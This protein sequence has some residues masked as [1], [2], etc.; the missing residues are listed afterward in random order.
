LQDSPHGLDP[1]SRQFEDL[2]F[3]HQKAPQVL[4]VHREFV[5]RA[6]RD[7]TIAALVAR[8]HGRWKAG[9][10]AGLEQAKASGS[11]RCDIDIDTVAGLVISTA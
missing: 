3:Y 10:V 7:R 11:L 5:A 2:I 1:F 6:P 9:I 8:L 4:A